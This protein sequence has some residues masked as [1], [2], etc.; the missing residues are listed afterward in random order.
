MATTETEICNSALAKIGA[1]SI[2]DL[3]EE[4]KA[5]RLCKKLYPLLRDEVMAAHPWNFA[6]KRAD[7]GDALA[8]APVFEYSY[9]YAL[10]GDCLRVIKTNL[11]L[12]PSGAGEA[13]WKIENVE[14]QRALVTDW[15]DIKVMYVAKITNVTLFQPHFVEALAWRLAADL[16]YPMTTSSTLAANML[17]IYEDR[18]AK[19]RSFDGQEGSLDIVDASVFTLPTRI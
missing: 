19:A 9:A 3:D 1:Q 7:L 8:T 2:L 16:A 5:G 6:I 13:K 10:P 18:L 14:D 11:N 15:E 4:S 17:A 12:E